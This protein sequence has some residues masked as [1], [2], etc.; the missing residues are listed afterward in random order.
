MSPENVE[1]LNQSIHELQAL[2]NLA[3]AISSERD[4]DKIV[5]HIL[6][7]TT[8]LTSARHGALLLSKTQATEETFTTL[9]RQG[10]RR[11][12]ANLQ[13]MYMVVAGWVLKHRQPVLVSD[14]SQDTRFPGLK[15]LD[16]AASALLAV[17]IQTSGEMLGVLLLNK[18]YEDG[19]FTENDTRLVNIIASQAAPVLEKARLLKQLQE[20]NRYLK[21]EV[22]RRYSFHEI[23]GRSPAMEKVFTLLEKIIPTDGRVLIQGESGTG[24]ELIARAIHY[25][26]PR[27]KGRFVAIDCGALPENLLESELFGHVRGAFTGATE[28]KKGLFQTA[29]GGTLFLD[30]INNTSSTLQAKL[31]RAIQEGEIR[32]VGGTKPIKVDVRV[33][34]ASSKDLAQAVKDGLFR[35]DLYFRLNVLTISLPPL[36]ER[37]EDILLLAE[38]FLR[39][40]SEKMGKRLTGFT[41]EAADRLLSYAW[42][43]NIRELE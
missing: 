41:R 38:H 34:C 5:E 11:H 30:E 24:K 42:P 19:P 21:R 37:K 9:A 33:V 13:K 7:Q 29:D 27:K 23:I 28:S 20:E 1:E 17:P 16:I 8:A 4:Q 32:P 2:N 31:L 14:I 12:E 43:G 36:R 18:N 26:S 3:L 15:M 10:T 40:F 6:Q 35:E 39:R 25:N 22:E